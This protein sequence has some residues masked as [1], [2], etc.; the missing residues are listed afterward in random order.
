MRIKKYFSLVLLLT[1]VLAFSC[2][3]VNRNITSDYTEE[4]TSNVVRVTFPEGITV[5][6]IAERLKKNGVCGAEE[7]IA[8]SNKTEYLDLFGIDIASPENRM[9]LLEGYLFP[10]TYDFYYGENP[11]SVLKK[12]LVNTKSKLT[13]D[14]L[15]RCNELELSADKLLTLASIVQRECG[16]GRDDGKVASVIFNRLENSPNAR[17]QCDSSTYYLRENVKPYVDEEKYSF[18]VDLYST[19]DT[20]GLPEGPINNC[21]IGVLNAV[22]YPEQTDYQFFVT[23]NQGNFYFSET[24]AEHISN[25]KKAGIY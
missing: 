7:F 19:Y 16:N 9:Y 11:S 17:L 20:G 6:G 15:Q 3:G 8:E 22:L 5:R 12:F 23:D 4:T 10:D 13:I 18:Y 24:Y 14:V 2:C 21:G 1:A 25:C